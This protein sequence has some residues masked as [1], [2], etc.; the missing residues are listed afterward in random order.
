MVPGALVVAGAA[1]LV[2]LLLVAAG[3]AL[4]FLL[5]RDRMNKA[6]TITTMMIPKLRM[7]RIR[8][9]RRCSASA[10]A[11]RACLPC[12]LPLALLGTHEGAKL[13]AGAVRVEV[14]PGDGYV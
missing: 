2:L 12:L 8:C 5:Y 4:S 3:W 10:A 6:A 13:P 7:L 1:E 9:L 11:T 14:G